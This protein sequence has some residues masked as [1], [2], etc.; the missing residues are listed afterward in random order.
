MLLGQRHQF[1]MIMG[2]RL[3][4]RPRRRVQNLSLPKLPSS[5]TPQRHGFWRNWI[6]A[7]ASFPRQSASDI[8]VK[9]HPESSF[10]LVRLE[11][12]SELC[13]VPRCVSVHLVAILRE[14][15][16]VYHKRGGPQLPQML[17]SELGDQ[18]RLL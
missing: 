7:E 5:L 13:S 14:D 4:L 12:S 11:V 2:V 3:S 1:L 8:N 16:A 18:G 10:Y 9:T 17:P 15:R 6:Q